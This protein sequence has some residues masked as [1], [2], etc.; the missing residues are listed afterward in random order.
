MF[1]KLELDYE[2][3][4]YEYPSP[5]PDPAPVKVAA[6][7]AK[8]RISF[9]ENLYQAS[10]RG[11]DNLKPFMKTSQTTPSG[12]PVNS[13]RNTDLPTRKVLKYFI[14]Y[15]CNYVTCQSE[16]IL[17]LKTQLFYF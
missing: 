3:E 14:Y 12:L 5:E 9:R 2:D 11:T 15:R 7:T 17:F 4:S 1:K 10:S 6:A 8:P 16:Q 13:I